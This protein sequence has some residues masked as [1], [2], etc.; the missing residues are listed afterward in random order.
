MKT[1]RLF[2]F[3]FCSFA[4]A[5]AGCYGEEGPIDCHDAGI[6]CRPLKIAVVCDFTASQDGSTMPDPTH[7]QKTLSPI[8]DSLLPQYSQIRLFP[9][10]AGKYPHDIGAWDYEWDHCERARME[11]Y[12]RKKRVWREELASIV[13]SQW[14]IEREAHIRMQPRSCIG[15]AILQAGTFLQK[16]SRL[17]D[18]RLLV[19][20]DFL[21]QCQD[22]LPVEPVLENTKVYI[23][24]LDSENG[25]PSKKGNATSK[26]YWRK[27][28]MSMGADSASISYEIG[29][30]N[31]I[32][33]QSH[34]SK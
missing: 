10:T 12:V 21:E 6:P 32:L 19:I 4:F 18:A 31:D 17:S 1:S 20:S 8:F 11:E 25:K 27:I 22:Q 30:P 5:L 34:F 29:F 28:L 14:D 16:S 26:P 9:V 24:Q 33:L 23:V 15:N 2:L 3:L 7:L 13:D